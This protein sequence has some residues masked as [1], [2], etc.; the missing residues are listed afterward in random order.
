MDRSPLTVAE[1]LHHCIYFLRSSPPDLLSCALVA[2]S[3]LFPAQSHLFHKISIT[4]QN[5]NLLPESEILL[6]RL[7]VFPH[8]VRHI[9]RLHMDLTMGRDSSAVLSRI[10]DISFTRV[11]VLYRFV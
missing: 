7:E 3:W 8:L 10:C 11:G 9:R 2:R 1:L 4:H 6:A 5:Y